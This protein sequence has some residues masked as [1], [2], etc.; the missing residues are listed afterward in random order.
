MLAS[1]F[2]SLLMSQVVTPAPSLMG[3]QQVALQEEVSVLVN[4]VLQFSQALHNLYNSMAQKFDTIKQRTDF[5]QQGLKAEG[6]RLKQQ[7]QAKKEELQKMLVSH[8]NTLL[9]VKV[10]E[11]KLSSMDHQDVQNKEWEFAAVKAHVQQQNLTI[12]FLLGATKQQQ[13]Q[14]AEQAKQLLR[15]QEQHINELHSLHRWLHVRKQIVPYKQLPLIPC[16]H[17]HRLR[18]IKPT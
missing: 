8:Q 18:D 9:Q 3:L 14:M 13:E 15:I 10:L 16:L 5:Y 4:G 11:E 6:T 1:I 7:S 2:L 17:S 12:W